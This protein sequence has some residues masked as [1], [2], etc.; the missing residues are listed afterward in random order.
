[1]ARRG[2]GFLLQVHEQPAIQQIKTLGRQ[3]RIRIMGDTSDQAIQLLEQ[4]RLTRR[5]SLPVDLTVRLAP[6]GVLMRKG[7]SVSRELGL[8]IGLLRQKASMR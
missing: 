2:K 8:F 3:L 5:K 1:M 6:F 4:G 7:D